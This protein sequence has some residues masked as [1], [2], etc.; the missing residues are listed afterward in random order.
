LL[1]LIYLILPRVHTKLRL[2]VSIHIGHLLKIL[3]E[4]VKDRTVYYRVQGNVN[5]DVMERELK[6][7]IDNYR[8]KPK[9]TVRIAFYS[10]KIDE[11]LRY[12]KDD[13]NPAPDSFVMVK[14]RNGNI[15]FAT[16]K[17]FLSE[18][19]YT[20]LI[21]NRNN[22]RPY[23]E[24]AYFTYTFEKEDYLLIQLGDWD[25]IEGFL[26]RK[27]SPDDMIGTP[28]RLG[29]NFPLGKKWVGGKGWKLEMEVI[30]SE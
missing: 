26:G 3:E 19:K 1:K 27:K 2:H 25:G 24:G 10:A 20:R 28:F 16:G 29:V 18:Q 7:L 21:K 8:I 4:N 30:D 9:K 15:I 5:V 17:Q 11:G 12:S 14:D 13:T 6:K 22:Y 23:F